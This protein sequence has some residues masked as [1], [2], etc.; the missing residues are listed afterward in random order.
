MPGAAK[1]KLPT[2]KSPQGVMKKKKTRKDAFASPN[3]RTP[4]VKY[5]DVSLDVEPFYNSATAN[6]LNNILAGSNN[7]N[8][9]GNK[10][11]LKGIEYQLV[12][13]RTAAGIVNTFP[14]ALRWV[15]V[16]DK[17]PNPASIATWT[18]IFLSQDSAGASFTNQFLNKPN[19]AEKDRFLILHDEMMSLPQVDANVVGPAGIMSWDSAQPLHRKGY[20]KLSKLISTFNA[21]SQITEGQLLFFVINN[22]STCTNNATT[23]YGMQ[24]AVRTSYMDL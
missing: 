9:V 5:F 6:Q 16:Y 20:I 7:W 4:E 19:S 14:S 21:S 15:L 17:T 12:V 3:A 1:R 13:Y 8:R 24:V 23:P 18:E 2:K 10:V 22:N 11:T